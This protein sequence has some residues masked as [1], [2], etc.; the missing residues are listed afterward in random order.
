MTHFEISDVI[1]QAAYENGFDRHLFDGMRDIYLNTHTGAQVELPCSEYLDPQTAAQTI[2]Q[3]Y[4][5]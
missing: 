4:Q 2:A 3:F 1:A 5:A